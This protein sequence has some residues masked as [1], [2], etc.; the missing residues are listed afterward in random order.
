MET[1]SPFVNVRIP[2]FIRNGSKSIKKHFFIGLLLTDGGIRK[3]GTI[4]FHMASKQI[5]LDLAQLI[6]DIWE[7]KPTY[8]EYLQRGK[9]HSFQLNLKK[10]DSSFVLSDMVTWH[11]LVLR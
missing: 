7:I 11:N 9:Y 8:K 10:E 3:E 1:N 6:L 4:V 2:S 5:I